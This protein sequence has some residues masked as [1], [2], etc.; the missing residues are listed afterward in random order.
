MGGG[1]GGGGGEGDKK[2]AT[3][4]VEVLMLFPFCGGGSLADVVAESRKG[5][6]RKVFS[7]AALLR[8]FADVADGLSRL[9]E[10][11]N[12]VHY[13][14][15]PHNI[16]LQRVS[17]GEEEREQQQRRRHQQHRQETSFRALLGDWGSARELPIRF[18]STHAG[19]QLAVCEEAERNSTAAFRAPELWDPLSFA[20]IAESDDGGGDG[21][22]DG[23]GDGGGRRAGGRREVAGGADVWSLGASLFACLGDG[24]SP[25]EVAAFGA[26]GGS[27]GGG[28]GGG[29]G[30]L[31][32]AACSGRVAWPA[33]SLPPPPD[34]SSSSSS[35]P[36]S[37]SSSVPSS[38]VRAFVERCLSLHPEER[39][40][41][42]AF[43]A[44]ARALAE[45]VER[46]EEKRRRETAAA[47]KR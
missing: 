43:A 24:R 27:S 39:P 23:D 22:G 12:L 26:P 29:G 40:S 45:G 3:A 41:A 6:G 1:G 47:T 16:F 32:L 33:C 34:S 9:H 15:K 19:A 30:S 13:D 31:A 11:S 17:R 44:E 38:A 42:A 37:S 20:P 2:G 36:S 4:T 46:E 35:P 10:E 25:S 5:E 8:L 28:G 21:D 7:V 14:V 18:P